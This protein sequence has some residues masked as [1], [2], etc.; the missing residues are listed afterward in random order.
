[1]RFD[2]CSTSLAEGKAPSNFTGKDLT[3]IQQAMELWA[4]RADAGFDLQSAT[5]A[6]RLL[7]KSRQTFEVQEALELQKTEFAKRVRRALRNLLAL[8]LCTLWHVSNASLSQS[9]S[10]ILHRLLCIFKTESQGCWLA[11]SDQR[12]VMLL[13]TPAVHA[14]H[15][16]CH[17][18]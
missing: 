8:L 16:E 5:P 12:D 4:C 3:F 6:T 17:A 2:S 10:C 13:L 11:Q 15:S 7:E 14:V 1:M 9:E 18:T